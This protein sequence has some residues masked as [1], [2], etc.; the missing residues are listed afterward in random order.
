VPEG[1]PVRWYFAGHGSGTGVGM[2]QW[3]ALGDAVRFHW[4]YRRLLAHFYGGTTAARLGAVGLPGRLWLSVIVLQNLDLA[5]EKGFDPVLSAS[6]PLR[7]EDGGTPPVVPRAAASPESADGLAGGALPGRAVTTGSA[8]ARRSV[9]VPA[10]AAVDLRMQRNGTWDAYLGPTCAAA[11]S[12]GRHHAAPLVRDLLDPLAV[13]LGATAPPGATPARAPAAGAGWPTGAGAGGNAG[14]EVRVCLHGGGNLTVT[15]A[16]QALDHDGNERTLGLVPLESYV[17]AVT[18]AE[19]PAAWAGLGAP[20]LAGRAAG[21]QALAAQ[22]VAVRSF[23]VAS[24]L[25]GGWN[26]YATTCDTIICQV[27]AGESATAPADVAAAALTA[28]QVRVAGGRRVVVTTYSASSGGWT[29]P[30]PFPAVPDLGDRCFAPGEPAAC[31]PLHTW[32]TSVV[33]ASLSASLGGLGTLRRLAAVRR[34]G[35]GAFGGRVLQ[36]TVVGSAGSRTLSGDA[37]AIAAGLPSAWFARIRAPSPVPSGT[38]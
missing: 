36:V 18:G 33:T 3:G 28:G 8:A 7:I 27:Y 22:A 25:T 24:G 9:V 17:A 30:G 37:F 26:G 10:G 21:F 4:S 23:A 35:D 11:L 15:G 5:D 14:G 38:A 31:N 16:V 34:D 19:M 1:A 13:P 6:V 29:A 32:R 20:G 2:G 12:A